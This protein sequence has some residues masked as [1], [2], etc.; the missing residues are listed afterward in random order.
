MKERMLKQLKKGEWFTLT[1]DAEPDEKKVYV[2]DDY[3]RST[4]RYAVYKWTDI[5]AYRYLKPTTKVYT[6]FTF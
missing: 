5:C 2:K 4:K 1:P 3:D 6:D